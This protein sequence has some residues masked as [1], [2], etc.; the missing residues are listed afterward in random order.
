VLFT[1][2]SGLVGNIGQANYGAAKMGIVGLSRIVAMEGASKNIRSNCIAPIAWTRM[3]QTIPVKDE[4]TAERRRH[5]AAAIRA[6]QPARLAV[7]L[8]AD[9]SRAVS[10]QIFGSRGDEITLY[11]QPRPIET[12]N[13]EEGWSVEAIVRE[14]LP[15]MSRSF[16]PAAKAPP[17]PVPPAGASA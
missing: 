4:A 14:A 3:T 2:G 10:G 13:R 5:M 17:R 1:S 12:L 7:A 8:L 11:S 6:D 16:F 9:E 15:T